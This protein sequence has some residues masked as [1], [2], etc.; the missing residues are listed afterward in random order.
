[1]IP[2]TK[3][4]EFAK[5]KE[6]IATQPSEEK[7]VK[8]N[9][10]EPFLDQLTMAVPNPSTQTLIT[11]LNKAVNCILNIFILFFLVY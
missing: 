4:D 7:K 11:Y 8:S 1:M 3:L 6:H 9:S 5:V 2:M 10:S